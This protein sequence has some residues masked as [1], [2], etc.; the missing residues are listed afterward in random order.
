MRYKNQAEAVALD[1]V[2]KARGDATRMREAAN[3][4]RE[5]VIAQ[6]EGETSRFLQTLLEYEKAPEIT[7]K[8]LYLETMEYVLSNT[9]KVVMSV[10]NGNN[11]MYIPLDKLM[12]NRGSSLRLPSDGDA[13]DIMPDGQGSA[14]RMRT[15]TREGRVR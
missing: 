14:P 2:P 4:Y 15:D 6:A 13:V 10:K 3:A 9:S 8:R 7:R 12:E 1:I 11:L 5:R